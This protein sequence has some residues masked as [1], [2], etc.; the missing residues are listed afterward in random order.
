MYLCYDTETGQEVAWNTVFLGGLPRDEQERIRG[1]T[2]IL[3]QLSHPAII[4]FGSTWESAD[5]EEIVFTTEIVT[6]G[7]LKQYI[8]RVKGIKLKVVK[9]C[10]TRAGSTQQRCT[11]LSTA[12][13]TLRSLSAA[14]LLPQGAVRS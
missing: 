5:K 1:E 14:P 7:T 8:N 6:S 11:S 10:Q 4:S 2:A 12:A 9:N 13:L 3:R